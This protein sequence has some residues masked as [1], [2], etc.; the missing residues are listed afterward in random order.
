MCDTNQPNGPVLGDAEAAPS[1]SEACE[2]RS[3]ADAVRRAKLE[4]EK[5]QKLYDEVR[6]EAAKRIEEV[7]N[8][9]VGDLID[10]TLE[11]VRKRPALGLG[12]AALAGFFF[13]RLFRR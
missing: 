3:A 8:T 12:L 13:G 2:V 5:A 11:T 9:T 10:G 4:L 1:E 7:R 6:Q